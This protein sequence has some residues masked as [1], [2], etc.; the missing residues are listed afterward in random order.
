MRFYDSTLRE[1][2][3]MSIFVIYVKTRHE[4]P[5][6]CCSKPGVWELYGSNHPNRKLGAC[7]AHR[8]KTRVALVETLE[9]IRNLWQRTEPSVGRT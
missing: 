8:E 5:C 6:H 2:P 3:G 9:N 4:R 7:D 1:P